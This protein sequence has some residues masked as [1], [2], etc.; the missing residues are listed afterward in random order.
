MY[1]IVTLGERKM[2]RER[3]CIAAFLAC[4]MLFSVLCM[5]VGLA[6]EETV[7]YENS[8]D[9]ETPEAKPNGLS[10]TENA[11]KEA[12][13]RV[14]EV[15]DGNRVLSIHRKEGNTVGGSAGPRAA[16]KLDLTG[17]D[18]LSIRFRAKAD[19]ASPS[20]GLYSGDVQ[21]M[22]KFLNVEESKWVDVSVEVDLKEMTYTMKQLH[23]KMWKSN[24]QEK[25]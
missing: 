10:V 14:A 4:A 12:L 25:N 19:G 18:S 15:E 17:R 8:F 7:L 1:G 3:K 16:Y 2:R 11:E 23:H 24:R 6:A 21:K 13:V 5:P 20:V 22:T 9:A